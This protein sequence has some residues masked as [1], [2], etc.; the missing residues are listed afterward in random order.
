MTAERWTTRRLGSAARGAREGWWGVGPGAE[1]F[2]D[3]LV[4]WR[5]LGFNLCVTRADHD[6]DTAVPDWAR[7]TLA[8]HRRDRRP[9]RYTRAE[10]EAARTHD[11]V[12]NAAQ[13]QMLAEGWFHNSM[14]MLWAK[15]ILEWSESAEAALD[16]M[17]AL[18]N[19]H[20]LD[21]RD[22][23]TYAGALW[24]LGRYDRPWGPERPIFGTVRYMSSE[25]AVRKLRMKEYLA[26]WS[27]PPD[28]TPEGAEASPRRARRTRR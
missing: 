19:R 15:K 3:Q 5:E 13:R 24:A 7:R 21:G 6:R 28:I 27:A 17:I 12:W 9:H 2:L 4:T 18:M 11:R 16:T 26:R 25:N 10:L 8:R 1:A 22:P 23:N 20:A 14:R